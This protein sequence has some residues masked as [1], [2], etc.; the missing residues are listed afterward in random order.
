VREGTFR[1]FCL[2]HRIRTVVSCFSGGKDSLVATHYAHSQVGD[3]VDF[4]V[5]H[6]DTT[7]SL[8]GVQDYVKMVCDKFGWELHI[9]RPQESFEDM[10]RKRGMPIRVRRW[11]C[12]HLKLEPMMRFIKSQPTPRCE[13]VGLRRAESRRRH[14]LPQ[15]IWKDEWGTWSFCPIID[16]SDKDVMNYIKRFDLPLSPIYKIIGF[17]GECV[18]GA[19]GSTRQMRI[20]RGRFPEF[21]KR[22]L[23]IEER[24]LKGGSVAFSFNH[25]VISAKEFWRQKTLDKMKK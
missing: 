17:S 23:E 16:W 3:I 15:W 24:I 1:K 6:V 25:K 7:I 18:C 22:F 2:K 10:V 5:L 12:Y 21:F 11:C 19:F 14:K 13:I 4:K 20:I 9:V 8:P